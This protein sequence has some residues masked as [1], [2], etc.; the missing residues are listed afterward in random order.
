MNST[1]T[2]VITRFPYESEWGGEESHTLALAE[3][4]RDKNYQV[5][6]FGS[7]S[8][9]SQHFLGRGF[10]VRRLWGGKMI[11]T[12]LE[13]L[14]SL[15]SFPFIC[16]NMRRHMQKIE[17]ED[18]K[19]CYM[20][21]LNEK[22]FLTGWFMKRNIPVTWVEHQEFRAWMT[23]SPWRWLYKK[24]AKRVKIV[25]I[26]P[27]NERIL[28][29][30]LGIH[31]KQVERIING[32]DVQQVQSQ[33]QERER[34][35]VVIANR[36]I[37]KKGMKVFLEAL[38]ILKKENN[39]NRVVILGK[40]QQKRE[41]EEFI[42]QQLKG[43]SIEVHQFLKKE[44][45]YQLLNSADLFVSSALDENE[46]F[47]LSSAE[48]LAAGCKLVVTKCSGIAHF[49]ADEKE[50][51][52]CQPTK[53]GMASKISQALL[54]PEE[55]R[56]AARAVALQKFNQDDMIKKYHQLILRKS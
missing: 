12:A 51:F 39:I 49:L 15:V 8:V 18:I 19:A 45:Y 53:E 40:G 26:S 3:S 13:L 46:T 23:K 28:K 54:A 24:N 5:I 1:G 10:R 56:D 34:G 4:F 33:P 55:M 6:F 48:A 47:S 22:L 42:A 21:S 50:A 27:K 36:M 7:C 9:L 41:L 37:A 25:P 32:I 20:L 11:V 17:K 2:I 16:W 44:K 14:K 38:Y 43:M 52:I 30:D 31:E 35:L 29:S